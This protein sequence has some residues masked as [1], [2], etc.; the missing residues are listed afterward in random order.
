MELSL[1][2]ACHLRRGQ[3][4]GEAMSFMWI[5]TWGN[6]WYLACKF[7]K[8]VDEELTWKWT[9]NRKWLGRC[10]MEGTLAKSKNHKHVSSTCDDL[11][12]EFLLWG[13]S[14][15]LWLEMK[16][17]RFAPA[18]P[19]S[20]ASGGRPDSKTFLWDNR[21]YYPR[22]STSYPSASLHKARWRGVSAHKACKQSVWWMHL[23]IPPA[24]MILKLSTHELTIT[25]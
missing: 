2:L 9:I 7:F 10:I 20:V 6:R 12:P 19:S 13:P 24:E 21:K 23:V 15:P 25:S 14:T 3:G 18:R 11:W 16:P 4:E 17:Q 1:I 8:A 22:P 5:V